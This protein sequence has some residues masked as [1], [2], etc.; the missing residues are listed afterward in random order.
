MPSKGEST[1]KPTTQLIAGALFML[2][3]AF[4][5]AQP[6][7]ATVVKN[8]FLKTQR[9]ISTY[10]SNKHAKF[11]LPKGTVVQVAGTKHIHGNKYVDVYIDRLSYN[12]RKPLLAV[13]KPT[14]YSHWIRAKG[15]NFK[16]IHKPTYLSYY[17]AQSD[18]KKS[19]GKV[20]TETGNLWKGTRLPVDYATSAA[21]RLRVTTDG[22][23]EY[24]ASSPFVFKISP[25]PTASLKVEKASHPI[26]SGKTILTTKS[27]V[28]QL[29]FVKKSKQHYQLTITNAE[30]GTITVVPNTSKVKKILTNWIF[31]VGKES[32]YENNSVTTF[33]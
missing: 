26:A 13:K 16:Q 5:Q 3:A 2:G 12:I 17:A 9:S 6:A 10:N 14:V 25:K 32:W 27:R 8:S 31:K 7:H 22:Y 19:Q 24:D 15:Y 29:P 1:L 33:K 11:T 30:A 28:K 20:R 21:A 23:L 4:I 18:G